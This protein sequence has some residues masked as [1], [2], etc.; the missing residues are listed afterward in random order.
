MIDLDLGEEHRAIRDTVRDLATRAVAPGARE[1]DE[2][3]R[4]AAGLLRE[5]A[6]LGLLGVTIAEEHGGAGLDALALAVVVEELA[7]ADG[8]LAATVAVHDGVVAA[9]IAARGDA[10]TAARWLPALATAEHVGGLWLG[11][12]P[13]A[14]RILGGGVATT[15]ALG[16][17][18]GGESVGVFERPDT[19]PAPARLGLRAATASCAR[20]GDATDELSGLDLARG[21]LALAALALGL[22][23]AALAAAIEH[24]RQREQF[25]RPIA[26][27]QAIQ[28]MI[29]DARTQLDASR[30]LVT[31]AALSGRSDHAAAAKLLACRG[32]VGVCDRS[33]QI[34]GGYGYTRELPIERML[35][36]AR[37]TQELLG[38]R[39]ALRAEVASG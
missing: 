15:V 32:A 34:H 9:S 18:A 21:R 29:A 37:T 28:F 13:G 17:T 10:A 14:G 5:L 2:R 16:P 22:G 1:R 26:S 7:R 35:R 38:G 24:A 19:Q 23:E 11:D 31:R 3:A 33:L 27:F 4:P 20:L 6:E 8:A 39:D 36:D 30:A 12:A 25:R